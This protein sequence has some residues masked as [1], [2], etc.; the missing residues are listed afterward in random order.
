VLRSGFEVKKRFQPIGIPG[1]KRIFAGDYFDLGDFE[2]INPRKIISCISKELNREI[3]SRRPIFLLSG[4]PNKL[5]LPLGESDQNLLE[6]NKTK[7][8]SCPG[9]LNL[10]HALSE[11][12]LRFE[13]GETGVSSDTKRKQLLKGVHN[14]DLPKGALKKWPFYH[15]V[16][17]K[18]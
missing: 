7:I 14:G 18:T 3:D 6:R 2:I 15:I 10:E 4:K 13:I 16:T 5:I 17:L 12:K 1:S 9:G 8:A 11:N